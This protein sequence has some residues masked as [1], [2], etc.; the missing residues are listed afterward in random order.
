MCW[1]SITVG[2][3]LKNGLLMDKFHMYKGKQHLHLSVGDEPNYAHSCVTH[4]ATPATVW[5][6]AFFPRV[7]CHRDETFS[8]LVLELML[9]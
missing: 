2:T 5:L 1:L 3:G 8:S 9:T 7:L 4:A 6:S